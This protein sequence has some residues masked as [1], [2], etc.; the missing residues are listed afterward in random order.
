MERLGA[1]GASVSTKM[2]IRRD[3]FDQPVLQPLL[4]TEI[5]SSQSAVTQQRICILSRCRTNN[6]CRTPPRRGQTIG[7]CSLGGAGQ[8]ILT[9]STSCTSRIRRLALPCGN[10]KSRTRLNRLGKTC[11]SKR[12]RNSAPGRD[13]II[14]WPVLSLIRKLMIPWQSLR[15]SLSEITPR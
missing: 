9:L 6:S 1:L 12:Q 11:R 13:W 10:P 14:S 2:V 3:L 15:I 4:W 5:S 8:G 7:V